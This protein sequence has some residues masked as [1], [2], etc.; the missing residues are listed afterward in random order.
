MAIIVVGYSN[1]NVG[2]TAPICGLIAWL[3]KFLS[4]SAV[5]PAAHMALRTAAPRRRSS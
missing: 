5:R 3:R 4:L 1:R 2:K